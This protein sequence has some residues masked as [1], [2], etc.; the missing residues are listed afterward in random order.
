MGKRLLL[1]L[2]LALLAKLERA[3]EV[4][5]SKLLVGRLL[6]LLRPSGLRFIG[7]VRLELVL[8]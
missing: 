3:V 7:L 1:K 2:K 5:G 6:K 8:G 4:L